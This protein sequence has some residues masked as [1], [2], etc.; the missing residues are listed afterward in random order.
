MDSEAVLAAASGGGVR[1]LVDEDT[2]RRVAAM[3]DGEYY[4]A[5]SSDELLDVFATVP[6]HLV[7]TDVITEVSAVFAGF[8]ALLMLAA[9]ALG[10]RWSPLP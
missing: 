4:V 6:D 1:G 7:R 9:V 3:T 2:L 5:E 8:A 10:L